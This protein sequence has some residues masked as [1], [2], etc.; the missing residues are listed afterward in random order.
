MGLRREISGSAL[1]DEAAG[2]APGATTARTLAP[3][4]EALDTPAQPAASRRRTGVCCRALRRLPGRDSHP[5]VWSSFLD[6]P[7]RA[8]YI[9]GTFRHTPGVAPN[10]PRGP[11]LNFSICGA[12]RGAN[13]YPITSAAR[14]QG[15]AMEALEGLR[16]VDLS[17]QRTGAQATQLLADFGAEVVW[18]E[19]P[20]G[21]RLRDE[22]AFP[23]YGRGKQ[24][25]VLD[26]KVPAS[27]A[28][29]VDLCASADVVVRVVPA[30]R[31]RASRREL[32]RTGCSEP[33]IGLRVDHRVRSGE[34]ASRGEGLRGPG[35]GQARRVQGVRADGSHVAPP[36][37]LGAVVLVRSDADRGARH[38]GCAHRARTQ[39]ART[40]GRDQPGRRR[41]AALDTW[42]WFLDLVTQRFPDA[43]TPADA[44]AATGSRSARWSTCCSSG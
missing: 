36:V 38:P 26:L 4:R 22:R 12:R 7:L 18:I 30:G 37:R 14:T 29:A 11:R 3:S 19:P 23:F 42:E 31:G 43:F 40:V 34:P 24:S 39:R 9:G 10:S 44:V 6:V 33:A 27:L 41:F 8:L 2:L 17:Q 32:R 1:C 25:I 5:Q 16:V 35:A 21:S 20:G 13:Q 15:G 28:Q